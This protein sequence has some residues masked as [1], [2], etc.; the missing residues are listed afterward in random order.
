MFM[1][2]QTRRKE[3]RELEKEYKRILDNKQFQKV[4]K[5]KDF[6]KLCNEELDLLKSHKHSNNQLQAQFDFG[7]V[8]LSRI[9]GIEKKMA[10]LRR[11]P[12]NKEDIMGV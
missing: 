3:L 1:L 2:R 9:K 7:C 10:E 11:S 12:V 4:L 8:L 5:S 6:E